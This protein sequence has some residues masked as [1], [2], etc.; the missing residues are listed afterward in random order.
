[1]L[2]ALFLV[3]IRT[4]TIATFFKSSKPKFDYDDCLRTGSLFKIVTAQQYLHVVFPH[5]GLEIH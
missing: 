2:F 4:L 3:D 5:V 1:M